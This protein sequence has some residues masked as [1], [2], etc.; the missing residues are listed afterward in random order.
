M[1]TNIPPHNL[2]ELVD[3]ICALSNPDIDVEGLT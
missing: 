2:S 3:G 1:A